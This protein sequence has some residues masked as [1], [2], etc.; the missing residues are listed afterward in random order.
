MDETLERL[1]PFTP[2]DPVQPEFFFGRRKEIGQIEMALR[3]ALSGR[4]HRILVRGDRGIGKTSIAIYAASMANMYGVITESDANFV[5]VFVRLGG[6]RNL[7]EICT[8]ILKEFH[9][10]SPNGV[11]D[12]IVK[13]LGQI[14][15]VTIGPV[16][17]QLSPSTKD[18]ALVPNFDSLLEGIVDRILK[19]NHTGIL[20]IIDESERFSQMPG[21]ADFLRNILEKLSADG[22][23]QVVTLLTAT[24][25]GVDFFAKDHASFPRLFSCVDLPPLE[26]EES[27]EMVRNTLKQGIPPLRVSE[28]VLQGMHYYSNG[29]PYFLQ[30]LGYWT[31][32][33]DTDG[34]LEWEDFNRGTGGSSDLKGAINAVGDNL[35]GQRVLSDLQSDDHREILGIMAQEKSDIVHIERIRERVPDKSNQEIGALVRSLH[36]KGII[37]KIRG[38]KDLYQLESRLL[39]LWLRWNEIGKKPPED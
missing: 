1:N 26:P 29:Y 2:R 20:F 34:I 9:K 28:E 30:E 7:D 14:S 17:I 8:R 36:S 5:S 35:F 4:A 3:G 39:K 6:C 11:K 31:F 37:K 18:A 13:T 16:G 32:E 33:A 24:P 27:I 22:Y 19:Q 10:R 21:A 23:T 15:G 25:E 38:Q 12:W